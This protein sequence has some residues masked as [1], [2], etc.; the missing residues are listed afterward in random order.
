LITLNDSAGKPPNVTELV[1]RNPV[2][3]T[4]TCVPPE[5]GPDATFSDETAGGEI[6]PAR[7]GSRKSARNAMPRAAH[8]I[9]CRRNWKR[10]LSAVWCIIPKNLSGQV[11]TVSSSASGEAGPCAVVRTPA[12]R[13]PSAPPGMTK[14][15]EV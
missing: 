10:D 3:V 11:F 5:T 9:E 2:P 13:I 12:P 14:A 1:P 8:T 15:G 6:A 7:A 4:P